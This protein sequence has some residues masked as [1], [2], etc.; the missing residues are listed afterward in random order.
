MAKKRP[1]VIPPG[2]A[3]QPKYAISVAAELTGVPPQQLRRLE[4]GGL[5]TPSRSLGGTRRYSDADLAQVARIRDLTDAGVNE[6]GIEQIL[7]L[8]D[9]L[10]ASEARAA[11]ALRRAEVAEGRQTEAPRRKKTRR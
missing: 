6:V 2:G 11:E 1:R 10:H 8:Q 9:A 3:N 5:L 7:A 4:Q